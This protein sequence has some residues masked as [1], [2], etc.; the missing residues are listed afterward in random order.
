[1]MISRGTT[2]HSAI[3]M[4]TI[5][6]M[7]SARFFLWTNGVS[8]NMVECWI[9]FFSN[10]LDDQI[11]DEIHDKSDHE[12][13]NSNDEQN[14]IVIRMHGGLA[15]CGGSRG[16]QRSNR[17]EQAFRDLHRMS[18]CDEHGHGL[19]HSAPHAQQSSSQQSIFSRGQQHA[20]NDLPGRRAQCER[21]FTI[22]I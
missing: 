7:V 15:K 9:S 10:S 11:G 22:G 13:E 17:V 6:A 18:G 1:M 19:A 12:Q 3:I 8:M 21:G 14:L 2:M 16:R 4:N 20:I 5:L